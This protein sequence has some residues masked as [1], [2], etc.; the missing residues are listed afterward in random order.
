MVE[1]A[2]KGDLL[3]VTNNPA[4]RGLFRKLGWD[5][6]LL[7]FDYDGFYVVES[8]AYSAKTSHT[9]ERQYK[10]SSALDASGKSTTNLSIIH[11]NPA[12]PTGESCRQAPWTGVAECYWA[13]IR[14]YISEDAT[15]ARAPDLPLPA[16]TVRSLIQPVGSQTGLVSDG[17]DGLPFHVDEILGLTVVPPGEVAT[18]DMGWTVPD[19][20]KRSSDGVWRYDV[21]VPRQSGLRQTTVS[22]DVTLPPESCLVGSTPDVDWN[23]GKITYA[24]ALENDQ[25][26]TIW[27]GIDAAT[28]QAAGS[29]NQ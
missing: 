26:V 25:T 9:I 20:A 4:G 28:C 15:E 14:V 1:V 6:A 10:F 3:I 22:V 2:R 8:N 12:P 7:P 23:D 21:Q 19:A 24:S 18:M 29:A 16:G 13:L 5:G 27:Y 17:A 11:R